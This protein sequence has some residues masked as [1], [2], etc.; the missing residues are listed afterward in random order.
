MLTVEVLDYPPLVRTLSL[1]I[2]I[3]RHYASAPT[4]GWCFP[5]T[6]AAIP[7]GWRFHGTSLPLVDERF[8]QDLSKALDPLLLSRGDPPRGDI[9]APSWQA[10]LF[11]PVP[12]ATYLLYILRDD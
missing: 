5:H 1:S 4:R 12:V 8:V 2:G 6:S 9:V 11:E 7:S 10:W 3:E